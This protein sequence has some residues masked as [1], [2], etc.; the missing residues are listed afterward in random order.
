M[1]GRGADLINVERVDGDGGPHDVDDGVERA[2]FVK[3]DLLH[4]LVVHAC[5]YLA[6]AA[7]HAECVL[8]RR[9]I[10]S[11]SLDDADEII[12]VAMCT[13]FIRLNPDIEPGSRHAGAN[14]TKDVQVVPVQLELP[15]LRVDV[16]RIHTEIDQ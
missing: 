14:V 8:L 4:G 1:N 9:G 12:E 11:L 13:S 3:M 2:D 15:Q 16:S 6:D 7:K 10:Q 5:L